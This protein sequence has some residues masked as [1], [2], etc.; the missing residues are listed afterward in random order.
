M[1]SFIVIA[2]FSVGASVFLLRKGSEAA[3]EIELLNN[4]NF[5]A[6]RGLINKELD[7]REGLG[8]PDTHTATSSKSIQ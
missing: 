3:S 4:N 2:F 8:T 7:E 5:S 6:R 1:M